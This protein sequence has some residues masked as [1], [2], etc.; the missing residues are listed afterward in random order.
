[1]NELAHESS[2]NPEIKVDTDF[3]IRK[4][5]SLLHVKNQRRTWDEHGE[6]IAKNFLPTAPAF[7]LID[8]DFAVPKTSTVPDWQQA[9]EII[10]AVLNSEDTKYHAIRKRLRNLHNP[11]TQMM[12]SVLSIWLSGVMGISTSV[13]HPMVASI[14]Y[15]A[16]T[17]PD[18][19]VELGG[20]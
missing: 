16:A 6:K 9:K 18:K 15:G 11:S 20:S 5:S 10:H 2:T 14:L 3:L 1:M 7:R 8:D 4:V 12:L 19:R 17:S 13:T